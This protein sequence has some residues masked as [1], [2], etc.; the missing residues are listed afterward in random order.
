MSRL[1]LLSCEEISKRFGVQPLFEGLSFG[2]FE[3]DRVGLVGPNGSGKTTLLRILAG[4]EAPDAGTRSQRKLLRIGYVSQDPV[5]DGDMTAE[6]AILRAL[7]TASLEEAEAA[8]QVATTLGRV[9]IVEPGRKV[10]TLSAGWR[11]RLAVACALVQTPDVLLMDEPTN[12]LDLD[13]IL[14]L[15]DL[16]AG[17]GAAAL[18]VSH[19]RYFLE[20]VTT[21]LLELNRCYPDGLFQVEGSYSAFLMRRE[22]F[23]QGQT[24][25][26]ETLANRVR[27]EVEWLRRGPKARTRKGA[28]RVRAAQQLVQELEDVRERMRTGAVGIELAA[29]E[30]K[31]KK[32]LVA[33]GLTKDLAGR[34]VLDGVS[35]A[36]TPGMRL[37]LLGPSG[38]GKSTLLELL[39]GRLPPDGGAIERADGLRVARFGQE[40]EELDPAVSLRRALA[41]EGDTVIYR[42]RPVHVASWAKRFLFRTEQLETTVGRLSGG[43]RARILIARL[44][45]QPADLLVLDEPTTDLDI[46]TLEVLEENLADFPGAMVLVTRDRFLLERVATA[47]LALNETGQGTLFADY[48]QWEASRG[49][50]AHAGSTERPAGAAARSSSQPSAD[51]G[52]RLTYLEKREWEQMEG[53]ILEAEAYLA[54]A[55]AAMHEPAVASDPVALQARHQTLEVARAEVERLYARWAELEAKQG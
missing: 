20:H 38:S 34:R 37:G 8:G 31:S 17:E 28:A 25:Y 32:L 30:R 19:D 2:L 9:G 53:R 49:E 13:G 46:P 14:W 27:R 52:K 36:L 35:L 54:R 29:S 6:G 21:R 18:V 55:E 22:E 33:R 7:D 48:A 45:L 42:E 23:L 4:L 24:N 41:P 11:K 40:R 39:A 10:A 47:I 15:E 16:L 51:G 44:M 3:G 5:L 50:A 1:P 26:Q 43:E 12:H